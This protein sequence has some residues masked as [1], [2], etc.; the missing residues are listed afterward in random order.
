MRTSHLFTL[1]ILLL[2]LQ[3][4]AE[5]YDVSTTAELREAL[6]SAAAAGGDNT[7]KLAAGTY[8]TQDDASGTLEYFS[9][10]PGHLRLQSSDLE[11]KAVLD[12]ASIERSLLVQ[13]QDASL[14]V[15][16]IGVRFQNSQNSALHIVSAESVD[17]SQSE[18]YSN[19]SDIGGGAVRISQFGGEVLTISDSIFDSNTS[20]SDGGAVWLT[21][22][23]YR[24]MVEIHD[25]TFINNSADDG[26][27]RAEGGAI[28]FPSVS[29]IG[30]ING[31][32][33]Q[34]FRIEG[35]TF[36]QN[37][38]S[39]KG[40]AISSGR[41]SIVNSNFE[42]NS[43]LCGNL[44]ES[45]LTIVQRSL[46][47]NNNSSGGRCT[48]GA[49]DRDRLFYSGV[50]LVGNIFVNNPSLGISSKTNNLLVD[51]QVQPGAG[52]L[53]NNIIVGDDPFFTEEQDLFVDISNNYINLDLIPDNYRIRGEG[54]IF[55]GVNLGFVN[56]NE[57]DYRLTPSS[58]LIDAGT[59][60]PELAYITDYDFTGTT[61]RV[62]GASIDIGP[63]EYDGEAP[64]DSDGDGLND[65]IDNCPS[66]S[67]EDQADNDSDGD[68]DACDADDDNDGTN[69]EEDAFPFDDTES[70]DTDG[71]GIGNNEDDD[72]DGDGFLD[73]FDPQPVTANVFAIDS[74]G[75]GVADS[76]DDY[77]TDAAKQFSSEGDFDGDGFSNDEEV[78]SC[79]NPFDRRSQPRSSGLP[80]SL[81][82][83]YSQQEE[84]EQ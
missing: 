50:D 65:N 36:Q 52:A 45:D 11:N 79:T 34:S 49:Q 15:T 13:V 53:V 9:D 6:A 59:T 12:G 10:Q 51:T 74:D 67:N 28:R 58:G 72:D 83:I 26:N 71:D 64:P 4:F 40:G 76:R 29:T 84:P 54:N 62:I 22:A 60:D 61:A 3:T 7:I 8:S 81:M 37:S 78:E 18:F 75:D 2:P 57:G 25:S 20:T 47:L 39:G 77:P 56:A 66:I 46:F 33:P 14:M 27:S 63:Y 30:I 82:Y 1:L 31:V 48:D 35:S 43:G 70:L 73:N 44:I 21:G 38:S 42:N 69:D 19:H 23:I 17:I 41:G 24:T 32:L 55:E 16:I 80:V 5:V 68:G